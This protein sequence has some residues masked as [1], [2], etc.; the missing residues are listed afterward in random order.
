MTFSLCSSVRS[1]CADG[2]GTIASPRY[3]AFVVVTNETICT[4]SDDLARNSR[5][6][7]DFR[8][9]D[10]VPAGRFCRSKSDKMSNQTINSTFQP[11][12]SHPAT[13]LRAP[14]MTPL[15]SPATDPTSL[16]ENFRGNYGSELLTAAVSHFQL[17]DRLS[18][19]P[20]TFDELRQE[21]QLQRRPAIVL[22]TALLAMKLLE[23]NESEAS[24]LTELALGEW[25]V[26]FFLSFT[27]DWYLFESSTDVVLHGE[28]KAKV[29]CLSPSHAI[30]C[31]SVR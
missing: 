25:L 14:A 26:Q 12:I 24:Q 13:L 15:A 27:C 10:P 5:T 6:V 1:S 8:L 22:L 21:L 17:F 16:F 31:A 11:T 3:S 30:E 28:E 19:R 4:D 7:R 9:P 2:D 23:R 20:M 18:P 29:L